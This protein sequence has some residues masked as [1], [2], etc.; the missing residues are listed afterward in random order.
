MVRAWVLVG[1]MGVGKS[2]VGRQLANAANRDFVDA[3]QL[4]QQRFGQTI[5]K[6]FAVYGEEAF[7]QH[8]TAL[9]R[10]LA[11]GP[12][13]LSTGGGVVL[14]EENWQEIERL[15][16]SIYLKAEAKTLIDR[17]ATGVR[18][19]PLLSGPDW[20]EKV[21]SLL[22]DRERLYRRADFTIDVDQMSLSEVTLTLLS[23]L[24]RS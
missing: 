17:L 10:S 8:E 18:R 2:A 19:R 11:P 16:P 3:D 5:S 12:Y 6:F 9:L 22:E 7:R 23:L 13:V 15:G 21:A 4:L 1:M 24:N 20:Q 14:R